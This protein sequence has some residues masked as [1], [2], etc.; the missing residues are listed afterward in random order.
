MF[1]A[2]AV[3]S[4]AASFA[5]P[6]DAL[7]SLRV[8]AALRTGTGCVSAPTNPAAMAVNGTSSPTPNASRSGDIVLALPFPRSMLPDV[9]IFNGDV[10]LSAIVGNIALVLVAGVAT[11]LL[12]AYYERKDSRHH[13]G[14]GTGE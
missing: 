12:A 2:T 8:F 4:A 13:G 10:G 7:Q 3:I 5:S 1:T 6:G 14:D 9:G 11:R